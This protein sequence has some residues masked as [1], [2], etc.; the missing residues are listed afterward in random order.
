[1]STGLDRH[2]A[3]AADPAVAANRLDDLRRDAEL[4]EGLDALPDAVLGRLVHLVSF[5]RF[6]H[7]FIS[8]HPEVLTL[9]GRPSC[10]EAGV[11]GEPRDLDA[12]RL[13]KYR[14]LLK[15]TWMDLEESGGYERVLALLSRLAEFAV[16]RV[17]RTS[18]EAGQQEFIERELCVFALGKLGAGELNYS[19]DIDLIFV[20][21]NAE[22][23]RHGIHELQQLAQ[24]TIRRFNRTLEDTGPEGFLYR[25]D[26][27]L[28]PWGKSG[29]LFMTVDETE[30]YYEASSDAW[31]RFAWL[32]GRPIAGAMALGRDLKQR[33]A[34]FIYRRSLSTEDLHKF[35]EIKNEMARVR[36]RRGH[37][38]VKVGQGGIRDLEFFIQILQIVNASQ[39]ESLQTTNTL[40]ALQGLRSAGF[41][42]ESETVEI[43]HSYLFLRR[44]ENHLQMMDERQVHELPDEER[45][46]LV[47]ARSLNIPGDSD[48][49][50]LDTFENRL[51]TSRSIAQ[52]YFERI[53]PAGMNGT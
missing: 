7:H 19:S 24:D 4:R 27:K 43:T 17:L 23:S 9:L 51:F 38:N 2:I 35:V 39:H 53:L 33:L 1:M 6:L 26:L 47:I 36:N 28:R 13:F 44:L 21:A 8:R 3:A 52:G 32:R 49:E 41:V 34:P 46:R 22:E 40:E 11:C 30:N 20:S 48:D 15:I 14:E 37:W 5:S 50:I 12:L 42:T 16:E 10:F 31:E 29:P 25:V 45:Q 18:I